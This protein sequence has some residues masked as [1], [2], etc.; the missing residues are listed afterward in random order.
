MKGRLPGPAPVQEAKDARQRM[1][2][3]SIGSDDIGFPTLLQG[4]GRASKAI[5]VPEPEL[6]ALQRRLASLARDYRAAHAQYLQ[7]IVDDARALLR[8]YAKP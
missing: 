2:K 3:L 8:R 6:D 1:V 4:R 7:V 5:W